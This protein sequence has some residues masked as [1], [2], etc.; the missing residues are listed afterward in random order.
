M[1]FEAGA[2]LG[3]VSARAGIN[4]LEIIDFLL[5]FVGVDIAKDDP[6]KE[7]GEKPTTE[8]TPTK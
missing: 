8:S 1:D 2:T 3:I 5:G 6:E 7:D 4:P